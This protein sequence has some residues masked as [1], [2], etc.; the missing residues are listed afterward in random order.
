MIYLKSGVN[1]L[2]QRTRHDHNRPLLQT[3]NP[4]AKLQ[5]LFEQRDSLYTEVADHI[6]HTGKQSVQTLIARLI[7]KLN[8]I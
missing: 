4:R 3:A 1:D 7:K 8:S 6:V 2:W 5:E